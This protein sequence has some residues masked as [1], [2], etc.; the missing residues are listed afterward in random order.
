MINRVDTLFHITK[1][2]ALKILL[3]E[4]FKP[5]FAIEKLK[6]KNII[7]PM[8]SF[9]NILL[10]D[11]GENEVLNYGEYGIG[12]SRNWA[13][14]NNINPVIYSYQEGE[15]LTSITKFLENSVLV[16]R[17][18]HFKKSFNEWSNNK[19]GKFSSHIKVENTSKEAIAL[20][21][22]LSQ[23]YDEELIELLSDFADSIY[24]ST[25]PIMFLAKPYLVQNRKGEDVIAYNDREWR[26]TYLDLNFFIE[27][28]EEFKYWLD[29]EKPHLH[30]EQYRL[31]FEVSDISAI[32]VRNSDDIGNIIQILEEISSPE[33][34]ANLINTNKLIIGTKDQLINNGL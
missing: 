5:S 32:L 2:D 13:I 26:K 29:Q 25:K 24:Q 15:T 6:D 31:N 12:F 11:L 30:D 28:E 27:E 3:Q 16:S 4:G 7:V 10:R 20:A 17:L 14:K 18:K 9:S 21:D 34:V 33:V 8:V 22:Y 23:N 1:F 19:I